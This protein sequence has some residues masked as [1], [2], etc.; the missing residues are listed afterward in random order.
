MKHCIILAALV[1][2]CGMGAAAQ[3]RT[4]KVNFVNSGAATAQE[5]FQGGLAQL[6]NFQYEQAE[7]LFRQPEA[8]DPKSPWL[9]VVR[10]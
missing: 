3:S 1:A 2:I 4:G 5:S 6:H 8:S 7:H 9:I 10:P